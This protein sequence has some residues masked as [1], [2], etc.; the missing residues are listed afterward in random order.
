MGFDFG[1]FLPP[2]S[3]HNPGLS[4]QGPRPEIDPFPPPLSFPF[5]RNA[6]RFTSMTWRQTTTGRIWGTHHFLSNWQSPSPF[7]CD[8]W[9][10]LAFGSVFVNRSGG[11]WRRLRLC[12]CECARASIFLSPAR[13][14]S[15][16]MLT[17]LT[18]PFSSHQKHLSIVPPVSLSP[19]IL[20][21]KLVE[22]L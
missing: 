18:N 10:R 7:C 14:Q 12:V 6:T 16:N 4:V 11:V 15:Y 1:A 5:H 19:D 17:G 2:G 20:L 8:L 3:S 13:P 9:T 21:H 22:A